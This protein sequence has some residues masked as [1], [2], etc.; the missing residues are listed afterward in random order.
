MQPAI[1][2]FD[3]STAIV[4]VVELFLVCA[5]LYHAC[6]HPV[7]ANGFPISTLRVTV[8]NASSLFAFLFP[9][10]TAFGFVFGDQA[11][12]DLFN[13]AAPTAGNNSSTSN[14]LKSSHTLSFTKE[15]PVIDDK[16]FDGFVFHEMPTYHLLLKEVTPW[17]R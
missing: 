14:A 3:S 2:H 5:A 12:L 16:I 13:N 10:P 6:P 7:F 11:K 17:S 15:G 9:T 8:S 1:T 4:L